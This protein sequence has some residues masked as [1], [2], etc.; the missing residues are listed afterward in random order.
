MKC[1]SVRTGVTDNGTSS[2]WKTDVF[3]VFMG[4][5]F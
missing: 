2:G 1:V 4:L 3:L 5:C